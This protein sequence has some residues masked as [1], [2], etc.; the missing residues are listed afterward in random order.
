M[1]FD[2]FDTL[3][4]FTVMFPGH[5]RFQFI[6]NWVLYVSKCQQ[7]MVCKWFGMCKEFKDV[8]YSKAQKM[9]KFTFNALI[10][11]ILLQL[12]QKGIFIIR[13]GISSMVKAPTYCWKASSYYVSY[14]YSEAYKIRSKH[15]IWYILKKYVLLSNLSLG[16]CEWPKHQPRIRG[17]ECRAVLIDICPWFFPASDGTR[18]CP[19][20]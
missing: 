4:D 13:F 14:S 1:L 6:S 5:V 8:R 9:L 11:R 18:A 2:M 7:F 19:H 17:K 16:W 20:P 12:L 10:Q 3:K 15:T